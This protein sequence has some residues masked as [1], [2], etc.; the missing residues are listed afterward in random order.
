[1]RL[2][3]AGRYECSES[4]HAGPQRLPMGRERIPVIGELERVEADLGEPDEERE[5]RG[6]REQQP[7]Q[8]K[9]PKT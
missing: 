6:D 3:A 2:Q 1:M 5:D 8:S 9:R 4:S 7:A